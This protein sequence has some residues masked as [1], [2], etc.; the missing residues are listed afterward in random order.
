MSS[1]STTMNLMAISTEDLM[2]ILTAAGSLLAVIWSI[3]LLPMFRKRAANEQDAEKRKAYLE[4]LDMIDAIVRPS[5]AATQQTVVQDLHRI[6]PKNKLSDQQGGMAMTVAL[7]RSVAHLGEAG[8]QEIGA[9]MGLTRDEL[10]D[11]FRIRAEA[12]VLELKRTAGAT[13]VAIVDEPHAHG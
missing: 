9:K 8:V 10:M 6:E 12:A 1:M 3:V 5:V 13:N 2:A 4:A 7:D 11:V